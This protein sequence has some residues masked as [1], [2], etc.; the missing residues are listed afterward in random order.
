VLVAVAIAAMLAAMLVRFVA[1]TRLN[2]SR[3]G[4]ALQM[5]AIAETLLARV[6]SEPGFAPG[7][8]DGQTAPFL[9][10]IEVKPTTFTARTLREQRPPASAQT[11]FEE[12][13][14]SAAV[15]SMKSKAENARS[16]AGSR[17]WIAYRVVVAVESPSGRKH[18]VDT[19]RV[20]PQPATEQH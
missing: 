12:A 6:F 13:W 10:R 17:T 15:K 1:G 19:V 16:A 5:E 7:R 9:W 8:T 20:K 2:A 18:V 3:I 14:L 11:G 4:E